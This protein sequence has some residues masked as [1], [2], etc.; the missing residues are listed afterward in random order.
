MRSARAQELLFAPPE[1]SR[2]S[3]ARGVKP[4]ALRRRSRPC[5]WWWVLLVPAVTVPGALLRGFEL[6]KA[7]QGN[8]ESPPA[9]GHWRD[10]L[11][12][13]SSPPLPPPLPPRRPPPHP[14]P[15]PAQRLAEP[16]PPAARTHA[17]ADSRRPSTLAST[18]PHAGRQRQQPP[19]PDGRLRHQTPEG[20]LRHAQ[21]TSPAQAAQ[22]RP[23]PPRPSPSP[24]PSPSPD[25]TLPTHTPPARCTRALGHLRTLAPPSL[26][27]SCPTR[28]S[29]P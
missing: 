12:A 3:R 24:S 8:R 18:K 10:V 13:S 29:A 19:Q 20:R 6:Q 25:P 17:T 28:R 7:A 27:L 11:P 23:A 22:P 4:P 21:C 26:T 9:Q 14:L 16:E 1:P 2:A 15:P 5:S